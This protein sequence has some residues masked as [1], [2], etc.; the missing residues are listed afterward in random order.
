MPINLCFNG[1]VPNWIDKLP[2]YIK[3]KE[4]MN[5]SCMLII[6]DINGL[7]FI[8]NY[9]VSFHIISRNI[10]YFHRFIKFIIDTDDERYILYNWNDVIKL[11]SKLD[12]I[13]NIIQI[14]IPFNCTNDN[15]GGIHYYENIPIIVPSKDIW[16]EVV[17]NISN[18]NSMNIFTHLFQYKI[19]SDINIVIKKFII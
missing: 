12:P 5:K 6:D 8:N 13:N 4:W 1:Y 7:K 16:K 19:N 3:Y 11:I 18:N 15:Y 2:D 10:G 9:M 14:Q 17:E